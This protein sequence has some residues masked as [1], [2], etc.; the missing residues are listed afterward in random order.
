MDARCCRHTVVETWCCYV[1][2]ARW[3]CRFQ[4][5]MYGYGVLSLRCMWTWLRLLRTDAV[6]T[7]TRWCDHDSMRL[8]QSIKTFR[9][10]GFGSHKVF[11]V[12]TR[13][14]IGDFSKELFFFSFLHYRPIFVE[15][16]TGIVWASKPQIW[17]LI[18]WEL[19]ALSNV[20]SLD[21]PNSMVARS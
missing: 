17:F 7:S 3:C 4:C 5:Y 20:T 18:R 15:R 2:D 10:V 1:V 9:K 8:A 19:M 16:C 13:S 6:T 11:V 14:H 21:V 12:P